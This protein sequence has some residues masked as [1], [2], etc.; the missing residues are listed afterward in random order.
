[1]RIAIVTAADANYLPAACCALLSCIGDGKIDRSV[2]LVLLASAVSSEEVSNAEAFLRAR[3][4]STDIIALEPDRFQQF[5]IDG[6]V[7]ASTYSRLLLPE[8]L[9]EEWDQVLYVDAD[10]RV[11]TE[12]QPLL[13]TNLRGKPIGAVHDYMQ[14][15]IYGLRGSRFRLS[16]RSDAP[17]F[18]AGVML[19][20]WRKT[21]AS[22][23]LAK[24]RVFAVQNPEL[25][26]SHDQDALNKAFE[27]E[28]TPLDPRWN[29]MNVALPERILRLDYPS[30]FRPYIA[31]FAGPVK[32]WTADCPGRYRHHQA[33]YR[34]TLHDSPWPTFAAPASTRVRPASAG[35]P[36]RLTDWLGLQRDKFRAG[37]GSFSAGAGD[38]LSVNPQ[39]A[40][41]FEDMI[42]E[43]SGSGAAVTR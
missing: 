36:H 33:W 37:R 35:Y 31:H 6:H 11:M 39:L 29:F 30:E 20:D 22:G 15:L 16:L 27:G 7:S 34:E 13:R 25:C 4:T 5:R 19:F 40:S 41:L 18:N 9:G 26:K 1:M 10:A 28:W 3:H 2:R 17:Y 8:L 12:L 24:A 21:I 38:G 43:A 23:L 32:P 14:H 42:T